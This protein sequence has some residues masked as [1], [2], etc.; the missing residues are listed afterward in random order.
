MWRAYGKNNGIAL[1][2]KPAI[3]FNNYTAIQTGVI[4]SPVAYF[5]AAKIQETLNVISANVHR[6]MDVVKTYPR[7]D[8]QSIILNVY[9][10]AVMCNKH[11]GF[12][13]EREWRVITYPPI[14]NASPFHIID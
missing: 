7:E 9:S 4:N 3:F 10:M 8:L 14:T 11:Y 6:H 2:F 13:E 12:E 1:I 5:T